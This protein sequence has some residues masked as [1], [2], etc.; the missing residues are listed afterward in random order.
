MSKRNNHGGSKFKK[1][2][3]GNKNIHDDT[4]PF[5]EDSENCFYAQITKNIGTG[6]IITLMGGQ[7]STATIRGKMRR[8]V[9]CNPGDVVIVNLSLGNYIILHKY[10]PIEVKQLKALGKI[11][12]TAAEEA[13]DGF[14]FDDDINNEDELTDL[15]TQMKEMKKADV[16][17]R[18]DVDLTNKTVDKL[19][20]KVEKPNKI[21][22]NTGETNNIQKENSNDSDDEGYDDDDD[23]DDDKADDKT[24]EKANDE[25][26]ENDDEYSDD[27][28][29]DRDKFKKSKKLEK[30]F[31]GKD[32][33]KKI[34]SKLKRSQ[35]RNNKSAKLN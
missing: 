18:V 15:H 5:A 31:R 30:Q 19:K 32:R 17:N 1:A 13:E 9:W 11:N 14:K 22:M 16:I 6:F 3:R 25:N 21:T 4:L 33:G 20:L 27:D 34:V 35:A 8:R 23:D 26:A 28:G 29:N 10:K 24:D 12:F 7:E 2:K